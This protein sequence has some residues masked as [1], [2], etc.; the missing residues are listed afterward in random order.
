M[1]LIE[2]ILF[3]IFPRELCVFNALNARSISSHHDFL[4]EGLCVFMRYAKSR[5]FYNIRFRA[6]DT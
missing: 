5:I 6:V 4:P 3:Q 2:V 1:L